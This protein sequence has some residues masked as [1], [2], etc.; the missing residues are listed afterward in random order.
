MIIFVKEGMMRYVQTFIL[1]EKLSIRGDKLM[2]MDP[3]DILTIYLSVSTK[4]KEGNYFIQLI[5][6]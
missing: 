5:I 1:M 6:L 3:M 2:K 4:I